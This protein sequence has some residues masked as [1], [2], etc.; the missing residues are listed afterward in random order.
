MAEPIRVPTDRASLLAQLRAIGMSADDAETAL[1]VMGPETV[2]GDFFARQLVDRMPP[3]FRHEL[4]MLEGAFDALEPLI[5][6]LAKR[7]WSMRYE[8]ALWLAD[9]ARRADVRDAGMVG[10]VAIDRLPDETGYAV[11]HGVVAQLAGHLAGAIGERTDDTPEWISDRMRSEMAQAEA[12]LTGAW[13][14][15][16]LNGPQE[17]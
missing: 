12:H 17:T 13:I 3:T 7:V 4:A 2:A 16:E 1:R 15:R 6:S 9:V 10:A 8:H 11:V 5:Q 14:D